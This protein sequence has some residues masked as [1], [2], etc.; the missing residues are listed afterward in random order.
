MLTDARKMKVMRAYH[1]QQDINWSMLS[2]GGDGWMAGT[3]LQIKLSKYFDHKGTWAVPYK[4]S[5]K[6]SMK[7]QL[8]PDVRKK[9]DFLYSHAVEVN[10]MLNR[11]WAATRE[12]S[13]YAIPIKRGGLEI[14]KIMS[15]AG[16]NKYRE[17]QGGEEVR[18]ICTPGEAKVQYQE[19]TDRLHALWEQH[20]NS[21]VDNKDK[22]D[23]KEKGEVQ[24]NAGNNNNA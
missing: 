24:K 15:E 14:E 8:T 23:V 18:K 2:G 13:I 17:K 9:M 10:K 5:K 19:M 16:L 20:S 6:G 21:W 1:E 4:A 11:A 7:E 3:L 12:H 22:I